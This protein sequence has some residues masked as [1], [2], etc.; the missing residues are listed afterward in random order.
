[1]AKGEIAGVPAHEVERHREQSEPQHRQHRSGLEQ[2]RLGGQPELTDEQIVG[3]RVEHEQHDH[4]RVK[5]VIAEVLTDPW[6]DRTHAR[7]AGALC[8]GTHP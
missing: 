5:R 3:K 8:L 4:E 7:L 1:M 2:E 6:R